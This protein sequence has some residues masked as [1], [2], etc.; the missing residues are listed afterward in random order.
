MTD[1]QPDTTTDPTQLTNDDL[2]AMKPEEVVAAY[3]AG[4]CDV[5]LGR[6]EPHTTQ[7]GN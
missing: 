6:R 7:E 5:L 2:K 3:R 4:Q 1:N